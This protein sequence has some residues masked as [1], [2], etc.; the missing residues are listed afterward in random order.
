MS[1]M[2]HGT[3]G[4]N[5]LAT[6]DPAAA[7]QFFGQ[8]LGWTYEEMPMPGGGGSYVV[9]S[10]GGTRVG[11]MFKMQGDNFK[12]VPPHWMGYI[13]VSDVDGAAKKAASL[14]GKVCVPPTDIP[15][16]GRFTVINDPTG[17]VVSLMQ[18]SHQ[19]S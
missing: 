16:V 17:A 11:G 19:M 14:G 5:E 1:E 7:K 10:A 13:T 6:S 8:L 9:A 2:K 18:W 12:G 3:F 4:W 15:G